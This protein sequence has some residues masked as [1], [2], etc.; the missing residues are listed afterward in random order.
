MY[1]KLLGSARSTIQGYALNFQQSPGACQMFEC[2]IAHQAIEAVFLAHA[3]KETSS[4]LW[5]QQ[6][7]L[8][9]GLIQLKDD[10]GYHLD[11]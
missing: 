1:S 9:T 3:D 6:Q 4:C 2:Q 8:Q 10:S 11:M 5:F 7:L